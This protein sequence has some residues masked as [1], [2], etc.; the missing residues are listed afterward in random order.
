MSTWKKTLKVALA[1]LGLTGFGL[2]NTASAALTDTINVLVIVN[3]VSVNVSANTWDIGQVNPGSDTRSPAITVTNDGNV[4]ED[5]ALS[6]TYTP[7]WT[8]SADQNEG[9]DEFVLLGMF[10]TTAAGSLVDSDFGEG[11]AADD[12]ILVASN[13]ASA[14]EYA[15]TGEGPTAKGYGINATLTRPLVLNFRAPSSN[16]IAAQQ[17][18]TVTVTASAS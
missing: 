14:T 4:Q 6:L 7:G 18:M 16:T 5:M 17:S 12:L 2:V 3:V 13:P 10:T 1:V 9:A 15:R 8:I 11:G